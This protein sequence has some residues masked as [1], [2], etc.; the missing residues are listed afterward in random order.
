MR[1]LICLDE[2]PDRDRRRYLAEPWWPGPRCAI[3]RAA[4]ATTLLFDGAPCD[5]PATAALARALEAALPAPCRA[6]GVL[7][8]YDGHARLD[9]SAAQLASLPHA[10]LV[11]RLTDLWLHHQ[12]PPPDARSR[13]RMLIEHVQPNEAVQLNVCEEL[14]G[15]R[16]GDLG[17][18]G[19][20][21]Y[22]LRAADGDGCW[23]YRP[24]CGSSSSDYGDAA[25]SLGA[26]RWS[27]ARRA[28]ADARD[29]LAELELE[30]Q[31]LQSQAVVSRDDAELVALGR[32]YARQLRGET[33][34]RLRALLASGEDAA[35]ADA[36]AELET[37]RMPPR[38][39]AA[40][41]DE[42]ESRFARAF[43]V[44]PLSLAR[45]LGDAPARPP[46]WAAYRCPSPQPS[47]SPTR[48][49]RD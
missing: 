18:R 33:L 37:D 48:P 46:D 19:D 21:A 44:A 6:E 35:L 1:T 31:R 27:D 40:L 13:R 49:A 39:L 11:C 42:V 20:L 24:P 9:A 41:H 32:R 28:L 23:L 26:A 14:D 2:L 4:E 17:A 47:L 8:S 45:P 12:Q 43:P 34:A 22:R 7:L 25:L 15:A 16:L 3:T 5:T 29:R 38:A 10:R 30:R 36:A